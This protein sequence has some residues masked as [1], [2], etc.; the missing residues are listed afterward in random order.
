VTEGEGNGKK[1]SKTEAALLMIEKL[2]DLPPVASCQKVPKKKS[3]S[4]AA[5]AAAK[6]KSKNLIKLEQKANPDYGQSINPISRLIQI[7]QAKKQ[8]E[9]VYTLIA[10]RGM[11]RRR[12]FVMEV[13]AAGANAQGSGPNKKLAKRSA[14]ESLL[15]IMGYSRP[16]LQPAKPALKNTNSNGSTASSSTSSTMSTSSITNG[17]LKTTHSTNSLASKDKTKKLTFVDQVKAGENCRNNGNNEK[18]NVVPGLLYLDTNTKKDDA[19]RLL[20]A[21]NGVLTNGFSQA[22]SEGKAEAEEDDAKILE[23]KEELQYLSEVLG[24]GVTFTDFPQKSTS[25]KTKSSSSQQHSSSPPEFITLVK[26][27]TKPPK[28]CHGQGSTR[29]ASQTDAARRALVLLADSGALN[30]EDKS[31]PA[32]NNL[33][34]GNGNNDSIPIVSAATATAPPSEN[35]NTCA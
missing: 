23:P 31:S 22:E 25:S 19:L 10:E 33:F 13:S 16:S 12:E 5:A 32:E 30:D 1:S 6:K 8:K 27:S 28:V 26:L 7:Q 29:D 34:N 18:N 35:D 11:P 2:K 17:E 21:E 3:T 14:A 9:P 24:F 4:A 15:Q 20:Q